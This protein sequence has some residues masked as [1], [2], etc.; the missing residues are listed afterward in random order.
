MHSDK[1]LDIIW[2]IAIISYEFNKFESVTY[3]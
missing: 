1:N 3:F 2:D